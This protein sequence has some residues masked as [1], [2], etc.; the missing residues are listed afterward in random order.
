M[1]EPTK[2]EGMR[3]YSPRG[4]ITSPETTERLAFL[5]KTRG[6][7]YD[8][9]GRR[10]G[11][12]NARSP[13]SKHVVSKILTN[14]YS[15]PEYRVKEIADAIGLNEAELEELVALHRKTVRLVMKL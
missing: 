4:Y 1:T 14:K 10:I 13:L 12:M 11:K 9:I 8:E 2:L 15:C 6:V 7:T 3:K 5:A